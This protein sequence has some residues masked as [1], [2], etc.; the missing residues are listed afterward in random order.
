MTRHLILAA[1]LILGFATVDSNGQ[2]QA[3]KAASSNVAFWNELQKLCGRA[4][5]GTV[6][7]APV[8]D[9]TFKDKALVMHVRACE[10][11]RVRIPFNVGDDRSRTWVLTWKKNRIELRHDHRHE[12]GRADAVTMYGGWTNNV[13]LPTR[14]VFPAD[15]QTVN[16]IAA[17]APNVWWIELV[18]GEYFSYNLRRMGSERYFSIK[19]DLKKSIAAPA[20]PWGWKD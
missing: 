4:Y 13:G 3:N 15:D 8:D 16:V 7:A 10:K 1:A 9:T 2:T 19:F 14:Q 12:D 11:N 5:S 6:V 17:A 20:A 18:P